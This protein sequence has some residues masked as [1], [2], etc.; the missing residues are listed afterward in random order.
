MPDRYQNLVTALDRLSARGCSHLRYLEVGTYDGVRTEKLLRHWLATGKTRSAAYYGFDLWE[1]LTPEMSKAE[2]SK[3]RLPPS[4]VVVLKRLSAIPKCAIH[5]Y[6]GFSSVTLPKT[7]PNL[8]RPMDLIFIDAGHSLASIKNDWE[9]CSRLMGPTTV[10]LFDDYYENK[11]DYG[12]QSL[13]KSLDET[14]KIEM[15]D[16]ADNGANGLLIRMV[17][18]QLNS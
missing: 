11:S 7:C 3:S 1:E 16:P 2:L 9:C 4:E 14:Y 6:K 13:I 18:V 17:K 10:V 15:L 12:C 5:L 8:P